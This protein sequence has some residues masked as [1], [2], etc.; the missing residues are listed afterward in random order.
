[1]VL[2]AWTVAL[3]A[4]FP[5]HAETRR[6]RM[7]APGVR[8]LQIVRTL[9]EDGQALVINVLEVERANPYLQIQVVLNGGQVCGLETVSAAAAR[10]STPERYAVAGINGDFYLLRPGPLQGDPLG[11]GVANGELFSSP[12]LRSAVVFTEEGAPHLEVFRAEA[13]LQALDG[14]KY[15]IGGVN[16]AGTGNDLILYTPSFNPTT[17]MPQPG[18]QVMVTEVA[19]PFRPNIS[20]VARI[21]AVVDGLA[22]VVIPEDCLVFA[23]WGE[24]AEFLRRLHVGEQVSFRFN[25]EPYLGPLAQALGGGPRLVRDGGVSVEAEAERISPAFVNDRHPRTALGYNDQYLYWVTVD[26][27]QPGYSEGMTL[28][29]LAQ[30]MVDLGCQQALNLDGG[31]ST[32]MWIRGEVVNRPSDGRERAVAESL[33]LFSTAPR[34]PLARLIVSPPSLSLLPGSTVTLQVRG[35]DEFYNPVEV[36]LTEVV[37]EVEPPLGEVTPEAQF[38]ALQSGR[39]TLRARVGEVRAEIPVTVRARPQ[40]LIL[41]PARAWLTPG[42]EQPFAV[43]AQSAAG[44]LLP[45]E[46]SV[47]TW[48]VSPELGTIT[49]EGVF[50]AGEK[51][52]RGTVTA[53]YGDLTAVAEVMVGSETRLIDGFE[54]A[55]RWTFRCY[56]AEVPGALELVTDPRHEGQRALKLSYDFTT[57]E[58]T[59][60]VYAVLNQPIGQPRSVSVWVYG[61]GNGHWL[62]GRF[63]DAQGNKVV[64]DF[65]RHVDWTNEWRQVRAEIPPDTAYPI[66]WETIYLAEPLAEVKDQGAIVLDQFEGEYPPEK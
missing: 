45:L 17:H 43:Q 54:Q 24:A 20:Y 42:G 6:E 35:E 4:V 65:A 8:H 59:R 61:D 58:V 62:R 55:E 57:L 52:G 10:V 29:E 47:V 25:I 66:T 40:R 36:S 22:E 39:G 16:Q 30:L 50:T 49:A 21:R 33:L 27:R 48:E 34:G 37:W 63:V 15:S 64:V 44:D 23:G 38:R 41:T 32:T 11:L 12:Y 13:W 31:G 9:A 56:P 14:E 1:V 5:A 26:G 18:M 51:K 53:R 46:P 19:L 7:V 28:P 3:A 60:A 2:I